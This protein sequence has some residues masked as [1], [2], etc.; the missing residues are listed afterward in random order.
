MA[1]RDGR[2]GTGRGA[3]PA[4]DAGAFG[5]VEVIDLPTGGATGAAGPASIDELLRSSSAG[6]NRPRP[7]APSSPATICPRW[8]VASGRATAGGSSG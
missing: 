5:D 7:A 1:D 6:S 3:G 4:D 2:A 8:A